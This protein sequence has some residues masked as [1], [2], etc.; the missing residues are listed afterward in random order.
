LDN[1]RK[2]A[3][4][5]IHLLLANQGHL[6]ND[7]ATMSKDTAYSTVPHDDEVTIPA[8]NA[9]E[10]AHP[11]SSTSP[12]RTGGGLICVTFCMVVLLIAILSWTVWESFTVMGLALEVAYFAGSLDATHITFAVTPGDNPDLYKCLT[13]EGTEGN[14]ECFSTSGYAH[15]RNKDSAVYIWLTPDGPVCENEVPPQQVE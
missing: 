7:T 1:F 3:P 6:T 9:E 15:C 4:N 14:Y 11:R 8:A 2:D 10:N 5:R 13:Q 12:L